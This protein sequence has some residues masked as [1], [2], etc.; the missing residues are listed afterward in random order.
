MDAELTREQ[1]KAMVVRA[2]ELGSPIKGGM[3]SIIG[4]EDWVVIKPNIVSCYGLGP[5]VHDGGAHHQYL[6]GSVT[7]LRVIQS[8]IQ[9]L[10]D[11][12]CGA[13]ITIAEG[14]GEWLPKDRS[15]SRTA[16]GSPIGPERS[17]DSRTRQWWSVSRK[18]TT[19]FDSTL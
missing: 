9:Y 5:D 10:V 1:I 19:A 18:N 17:V 16:A 7:D 6:G 12:K 2:I 8:L 4:P 13:R 14:S 3:G 11:H 15:K